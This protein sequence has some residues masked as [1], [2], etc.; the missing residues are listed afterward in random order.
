MKIIIK[1]EG[2]LV[3]DVFCDSQEKIEV[4]ILDLDLPE[5]DPEEA[6]RIEARG[7]EVERMRGAG[8]LFEIA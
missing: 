8:E 5:T 3:Q 1:L 2:G 6:E 4:E 7:E